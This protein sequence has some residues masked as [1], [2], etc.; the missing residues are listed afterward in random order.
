M[1]I[2]QL[3]IGLRTIEHANHF[4]PE[5]PV[6]RLA[7][8]VGQRDT[9]ERVAVALGLQTFQQFRVRGLRNSATVMIFVHIRGLLHG[10]TVRGAFTV[11]RAVRIPDAGP[12]L[13]GDRITSVPSWFDPD[14]SLPIRFSDS[15]KRGTP[16]FAP[17][18]PLP[19]LFMVGRLPIYFTAQGSIAVDRFPLRIDRR[20]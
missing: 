7:C 12:I 5:A 13:V 6:Q 10:P 20:Y 19:R 1:R 8:V 17:L 2:G 11:R 15:P 18:R 3:A 14:G 4:E 9:G 16:D